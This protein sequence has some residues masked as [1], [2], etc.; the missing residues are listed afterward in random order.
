L[1]IPSA[2]QSDTAEVVRTLGR[3]FTLLG[4]KEYNDLHDFYLKLASADQQQI[5][6]VHTP[7][8]KGN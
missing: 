3:N 6:L 5:V 1:R 7:A 2:A 4:A 8:A